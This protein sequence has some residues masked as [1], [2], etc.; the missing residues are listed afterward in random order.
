MTP[1]ETS[2]P[3]SVQVG[4]IAWAQCLQPTRI[5]GRAIATHRSGP[6]IFAHAR[7][8]ARGDDSA[9]SAIQGLQCTVGNQQCSSNLDSRCD[10]FGHFL[11]GFHWPL[12]IQS[13]RI[14]Q[15]RMSFV[16]RNLHQHVKVL[17]S[18][19]IPHDMLRYRRV[20]PSERL[21]GS[22]GSRLART[23]KIHL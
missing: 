19:E 15:S 9:N 20:A 5:P 2:W 13:C 1:I 22:G 23:G 6:D 18:V 7:L 14:R 10:H 21:D 12:E 4:A 8:R 17:R 16:L 3:M 11:K